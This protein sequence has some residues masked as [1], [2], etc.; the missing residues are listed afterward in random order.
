MGQAQQLELSTFEISHQGAKLFD[1][2]GEN[3]SIFETFYTKRGL[4]GDKT[5]LEVAEGLLGNMW[6]GL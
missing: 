1:V 5:P 4:N 2:E 3:I 6:G